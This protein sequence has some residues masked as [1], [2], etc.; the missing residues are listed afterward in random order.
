[1]SAGVTVAVAVSVW[2][3]VGVSV[4]T[5]CGRVGSGLSFRGRIARYV[6]RSVR[7][8]WGVGRSI[9]RNASCGVR[10][11]GRGTLESVNL[12]ECWYRLEYR[13]VSLSVF[14]WA[15]MCRSGYRWQFRYTCV[16]V[17]VSV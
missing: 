8:G 1:M 6:C 13:L 9:G 14:R 3:L 15:S 17:A 12:W 5:V 2:V 4:G 7:V 11:G 10:L 16:S